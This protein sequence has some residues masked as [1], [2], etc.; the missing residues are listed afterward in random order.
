MT[1]YCIPYLQFDDFVFN[2]HAEG[3]ELHSDRYLVLCF[4]LVV[5][6]SLHEAT[7]ADSS[8]SNDNEFKKMVLGVKSLISDHLVRD[9]LNVIQLAILHLIYLL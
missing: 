2:F 8:V 6:D 7:F 3:S 1:T 9:L 4:E 5:H